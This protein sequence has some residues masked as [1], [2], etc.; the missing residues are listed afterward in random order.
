MK[1]YAGKFHKVDPE[2]TRRRP[3]KVVQ[4]VRRWTIQRQGGE[5]RKA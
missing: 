2:K 4:A 5:P 3:V 1:G